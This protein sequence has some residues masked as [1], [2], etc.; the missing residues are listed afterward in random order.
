MCRLGSVRS[1]SASD[2]PRRTTLREWLSARLLR[3]WRRRGWAST[4]LYPVSL[5]YAALIRVRRGLYEFGVFKRYRAPCPVIVVGNISVGGSGKTPFTIWLTQWLRDQG[6]RPGVILRGYGGRSDHWPVAVTSDMPAAMVGDEAV[7]L[8]ANASVPVVAGPDRGEDCR[9]LLARFDCDVI[10]SDDGFQH[11]A[12]YRDFDIVLHDFEHGAGNG[13]CL[14]AGPLR[15]PL[16]RLQDAD[17]V[18]AYGNSE[19]GLVARTG[20]ARNL[21]DARCVRSLADFKP[22]R[23]MAITAIAR[24]ERFFDDLERAGIDAD[25]RVFPDH[26]VFSR[27]D[28]EAHGYDAILV[29]EKDAVKL[30]GMIES[31]IWVVLLQ[32][33]V[34][35]PVIK[36]LDRTLLPLLRPS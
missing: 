8:A 11:L 10:V 34:S 31:R 27:S 2:G 13:R 33:E 5:V 17:L 18:I 9:L 19:S 16:S 30:R 23:V 29:T 25:H 21:M 14:P 32:V 35:D 24:P 4:A 6:F 20:T 12:L 7:L 15:E 26:H 28:L 22:D 3:L 36:H 1:E